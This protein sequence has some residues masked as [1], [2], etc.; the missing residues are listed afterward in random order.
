[1]K[2]FQYDEKRILQNIFPSGFSDLDI[3]DIP[4]SGTSLG[5][6]LVDIGAADGI[7]NSNS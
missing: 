2:T 7:D 1:M 4:I 3:N 5:G 6:Y